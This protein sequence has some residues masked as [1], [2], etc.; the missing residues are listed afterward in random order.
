MDNQTNGGAMSAADLKPAFLYE[1]EALRAQREN[2]RLERDYTIGGGI[3]Q[4]V[5]SELSRAR[6]TRI[7]VIEN[8]LTE[9]GGHAQTVFTLCQLES[10]ASRDFERSR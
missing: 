10:R 7:G 9:I 4:A 2:Y 6:E 5:H 8:R 1:L 3:E